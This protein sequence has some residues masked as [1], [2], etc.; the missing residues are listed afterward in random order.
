VL[1]QLITAAAVG[2]ASP[3][4]ILSA[5]MLLGSQRPVRGH[6]QTA[7]S[8]AEAAVGIVVGGMLLGVAS[9][10]ALQAL[11]GSDLSGEELTLVLLLLAI[12]S[13]IL[14]PLLVYLL[15]PRRA[16]HLLSVGK[17]WIVAHERAVTGWSA[18][19]FGVVLVVNGILSLP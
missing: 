3:A 12:N 7:G 13:C 5:I 11:I 19:V 9:R 2:A 17:T 16:D 15:L 14:V 8:S 18:A 1:P 6:E 10:S 4:A